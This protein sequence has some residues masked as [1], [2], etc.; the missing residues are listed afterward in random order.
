MAVRLLL[1][2]PNSNT[3]IARARASRFAPVFNWTFF[4]CMNKIPNSTARK[5]GS[6]FLFSHMKSALRPSALPDALEHF[7]PQAKA[8]EVAIEEPEDGSVPG[9]AFLTALRGARRHDCLILPPGDYPAPRFGQSI[10]VRAQRPGTVRFHGPA[11]G[12]ALVADRDTSLW[13]SGIQIIAAGGENLALVQT[14]GNVFFSDCQISGGI[15]VEGDAASIFL[16]GCRLERANVGLVL[17]RGGKAE[18]VGCTVSGCHVGISAENAAGLSVLHSRIEGALG[19]AD[20]NPGA[21]LHAEG[22]NV[23]CAGTIFSDNEM[24]AH[25]VDCK[26]VDLLFCQFDRQTMGGVMMKG[27]GPLRAHGCVFLE[28]ASADYAHITLDHVNAA[29]DYCDMDSSTT[30]D[31]LC[32][33]GKVT[34]QCETPPRATDQDDVLA[35]AIAK[36]HQIIGTND[37]KAVVE[38]LLHQAHAAIQRRKRGLP[39]PSMRFHCIFEGERGSGRREVV[40][41]LSQALGTLGILK[42]DGKVVEAAMEDLILGRVPLLEPVTSAR[43]GILMLHAPLQIGR[44][45]SR[46]SYA[47]AR[48]MLRSVLSACGEDT[49]LIFSGSR[50]SVRPILRSSAETEELFRATLHFFLPSPPQLAE[51]FEALATTLHIRLTT[52]ARIKILL[53]LH[54]LDDRKDRRF[55]NTAGVAKLFDASQKRYFERCS[56]ERNFDLPLDAGDID[57]SVGKIVHALLLSNPVFVTICPNCASETPWLPAQKSRVRCVNCDH[58][59]EPGWGIWKGSSYYRQHL[60]DEDAEVV[61]ISLGPFRG[62]SAFSG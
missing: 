39:V 62:R 54:M 14:K 21:G 23:Y 31:V 59:W 7:F 40:G 44:H 29:V 37:S 15:Q 33:K 3:E 56:R 47:E 43:G 41:L 35:A 11:N 42:S 13:L 61:P 32:T 34:R 38:T 2:G 30:A 28:Q 49:I 17:S 27:G 58:F 25:F 19:S 45:E 36:I 8:R 4:L 20:G 60:Q 9:K 1:T 12:P 53:G 5:D 52:R 50:E 51:M 55:L 24:G 16:G 10:A 6:N 26:E 18:I 22:T 48:A 46:F 57:I